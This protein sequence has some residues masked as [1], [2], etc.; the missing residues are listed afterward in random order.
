VNNIPP[1][2]QPVDPATEAWRLAAERMKKGEPLPEQPPAPEDLATTALRVGR[3]LIALADELAGAA[4]EPILERFPA[5]PSYPPVCMELQNPI[6]HTIVRIRPAMKVES[7]AA[8]HEM[9]KRFHAWCEAAWAFGRLDP[10]EA[11]LFSAGDGADLS[12]D[13]PSVLWPAANDQPA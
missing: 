1:G 3:Q 13:T 7:E 2:A 8:W 4:A 12:L 5:G 6:T 10:Q 9:V 11:T